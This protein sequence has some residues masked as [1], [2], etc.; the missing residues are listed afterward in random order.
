MSPKLGICLSHPR[1][2]ARAE[3][4]NLEGAQES[5]PGLLKS[6]K[7]RSQLQQADYHPQIHKKSNETEKEYNI[8]P[9]FTWR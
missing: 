2:L 5:I 3:F 8:R 9:P 7:I 1:L 6:L 4:L